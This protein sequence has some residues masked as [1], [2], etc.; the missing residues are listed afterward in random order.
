[1]QKPPVDFGR[2]SEDYARSRPG[3]PEAF[4][5]RC[6]QWIMFSRTEALDLATGPGVVALK[7]AELGANVIG[8]D[9]A[10][11]QIRMAEQLATERGLEGRARFLVARAEETGLPDNTFDLIA[12]GQCW[13]WLAPERMAPEIQRLLRPGGL[14]LIGFF[15][16]V[17]VEDEIAHAT[18][19][20]ILKYNPTW[21]L[22]GRDGRRPHLAQQVTELGFH[23]VDEFTFDH[24]QAFTHETWRGRIRTCNGVGSGGMTEEQVAAFDVELREMLRLR[25]PDEP[26]HIK[27]RVWGLIARPDSYGG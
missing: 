23:I 8:V 27:H 2:R 9:I 17:P 24:D 1:M 18:E 26:M 5:N 19:E 10:A 22:A 16:Y 3:F 15:D 21:P 12:A 6:A 25:F 14:L 4:Y 20:L 7:L 11:T 13:H